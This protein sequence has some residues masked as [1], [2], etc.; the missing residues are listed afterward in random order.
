M[1]LYLDFDACGA[2][3]SFLHGART[4]TAEFRSVEVRMGHRQKVLRRMVLGQK[5]R[6][7]GRRQMVRQMDLEAWE[8]GSCESFVHVFEH[9]CEFHSLL[10]DFPHL[11]I[12]MENRHLSCHQQ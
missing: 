3:L 11:V 9:G 2:P 1:F 5:V 6:S 4:K 10:H 7:L 8:V 12:P